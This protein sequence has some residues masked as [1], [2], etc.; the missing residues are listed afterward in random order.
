M[1]DIES[2]RPESPI[3]TRYMFKCQVSSLFKNSKNLAKKRDWPAGG[4]S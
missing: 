2:K 4:E 1:E 3:G